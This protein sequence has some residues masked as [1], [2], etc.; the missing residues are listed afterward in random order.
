MITAEDARQLW[1]RW[2]IVLASAIAFYSLLYA[3]AFKYQIARKTKKIVHDSGSSHS[4]QNELVSREAEPQQHPPNEQQIYT[5]ENCSKY[6][7][8]VLSI[9]NCFVCIVAA[10][11]SLIIE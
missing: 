8:C 11:L 3:F 10:I 7:S 6:A 9:C 5:V 2:S 1:P 4:S